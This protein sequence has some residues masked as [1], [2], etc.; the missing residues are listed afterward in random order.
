M[1]RSK[2]LRLSLLFGAALLVLAAGL[3]VSGCQRPST[4][5]PE[6]EAGPPWFEDVTEKVGLKF[7]HDAGPL[8]QYHMP[9]QMGSGAAFFDFDG[10]GRLDIYL[11]HNGGPKGKKN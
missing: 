1:L 9:E 6:E 7:V 2:R 3:W 11:L 5:G 10:D 4:P 8:G